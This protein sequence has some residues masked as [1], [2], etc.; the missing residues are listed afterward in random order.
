MGPGLLKRRS[1]PVLVL[2]KAIT[3]RIDCVL[4]STAMIRSKP[5]LF[6]V[7]QFVVRGQSMR[8]LVT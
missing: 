4:Q 7:I 2:G 1:A 5:K 3:S 8:E 6:D